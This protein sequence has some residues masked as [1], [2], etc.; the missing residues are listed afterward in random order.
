[1]LD[2]ETGKRECDGERGSP[3]VGL[4]IVGFILKHE[5][6]LVVLSRGGFCAAL[7]FR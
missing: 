1:M 2:V 7:A 5:P 6:H 3:K 4:V